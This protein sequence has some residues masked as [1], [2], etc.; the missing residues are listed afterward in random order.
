MTRTSIVPRS[1]VPLFLVFVLMFAGCG[2]LRRGEIPPAS[3]RSARVM[4]ADEFMLVHR[5]EGVFFLNV[6]S[7]EYNVTLK[8]TCRLEHPGRF[9]G[10]L[11]GPFGIR[12]GELVLNDGA[13]RILAAN[14]RVEEGDVHDLDLRQLTGVE[15]PADDLLSLFDPAAR[16]PPEGVRTISLRVQKDSGY[17]LWRV[18]EGSVVREIQLDP[19]KR[20]VRSEMWMTGDQVIFLRKDYDQFERTGG[21][22]VAHR[23]VLHSQADRP[24]TAELVYESLQLDPEWK[25]DPF[26]MVEPATQ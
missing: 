2:A 10:R 15:L 16:P 6:K 20:V 7:P 3:P 18:D 22:M 8:G 1:R 4:I 19:V 13:Y 24:V 17:W 23:L 26:S 25:D 5:F 9:Q 14:G 12:L 11:M 21:G